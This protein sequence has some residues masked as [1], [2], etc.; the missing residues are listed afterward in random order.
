MRTTGIRLERLPFV[1]GPGT[2]P[3]ENLVL[4]A[5]RRRHIALGVYEWLPELEVVR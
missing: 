1:I 2:I 3:L 4:V 5:I